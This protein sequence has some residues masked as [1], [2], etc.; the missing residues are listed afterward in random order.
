M[1][2]ICSNI[3]ASSEYHS[4]EWVQLVLCGFSHWCTSETDQH[5]Y[6]LKETAI[7]AL[8]LYLV[9]PNMQHISLSSLPIVLTTCHSLTTTNSIFKV[10]SS[11][12]FYSFYC[13]V[14]RLLSLSVE[15]LS[16]YSRFLI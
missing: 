2:K 16:A 7:S 11:N 4:R 5:W 13:T 1:Q 9:S 6:F 15:K 10:L 12:T 8:Y 3:M 14:I